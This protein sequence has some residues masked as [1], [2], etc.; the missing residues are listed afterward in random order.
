MRFASYTEIFGSQTLR[1]AGSVA[2]WPRKTCCPFWISKVLLIHSKLLIISERKQTLFR[3]NQHCKWQVGY[4]YKRWFY[5]FLFQ[6]ISLNAGIKSLAFCHWKTLTAP[7]LYGK[8]SSR[9]GNC[10]WGN[11]FLPTSFEKYVF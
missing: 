11:R 2:K 10:T 4:L 1:W 9:L 8:T 3:T 7:W 5:F 6:P